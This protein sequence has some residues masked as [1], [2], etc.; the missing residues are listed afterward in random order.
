MSQQ[1]LLLVRVAE[2]VASVSHL[3]FK[4][5]GQI[6]DVFKIKPP[7]INELESVQN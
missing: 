4:V 5:L 6:H 2:V 7:E 3:L 1:S